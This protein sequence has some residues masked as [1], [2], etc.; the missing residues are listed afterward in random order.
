MHW[1]VIVQVVLAALY[2]A[3]LIYQYSFSTVGWF[4]KVSVYITWLLC[5]STIVLLP[6]DIDIDEETYPATKEALSILWRVFYGLIFFLT[7]V[8]LPIAQEYETAGE[9]SVK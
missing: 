4:V 3:Y 2:V 8:L 1:F 9:F 6:Y 7:W 5:F